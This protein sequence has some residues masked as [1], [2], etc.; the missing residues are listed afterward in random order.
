[1]SEEIKESLPESS[2]PNIRR[3]I[4]SEEEIRNKSK[5]TVKDGK[6]SINKLAGGPFEK[7]SF[8]NYTDAKFTN[9][10]L[11]GASA[12]HRDVIMS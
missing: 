9:M 12:P 7:N 8:K 11:T 10:L 6:S 5:Q 3:A 4:G 1:M 2:L